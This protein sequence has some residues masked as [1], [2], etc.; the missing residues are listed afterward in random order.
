VRMPFTRPMIA[1]LALVTL[2]LLIGVLRYGAGKALGDFRQHL[3]MFLFF[4]ALRSLTVEGRLQVIRERL[5]HV[6]LIVALYVIATF[7]F[8]R[9]ALNAYA[10]AN[11]LKVLEER[12]VFDNTLFLLFMYAG[13]L[14][15]TL[16]ATRWRSLFVALLLA[17]NV[18]MLIVMQFR[19]Y[20]GAFLVIPILVGWSRRRELLR[21]RTLVGATLAVALILGVAVAATVAGV[22]RQAWGGVATSLSERAESLVRL[23][24]TFR[25]ES[26]RTETEV[27]TLGG[28][29]QTAKVAIDD[30]FLPNPILGIGLGGEL[31]MVSPRGGIVM[32]KYNIDNGFLSILAKF[33]LVGFV[34][35]GVVLL[36]TARSLRRVTRSSFATDDERM[37][38]HS[39][40]VGILAMLIASGF[41][42]A[43][44]RPQTSV[45]AFLILLAETAVLTR[46][47][48]ER[49]AWTP[50][51]EPGQVEG[52]E[53]LLAGDGGAVAATSG[54][55]PGA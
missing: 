21:R 31:P 3:P 20:W 49:K 52:D 6:M 19:T 55:I 29:Y 26:G 37:L 47:V 32:M 35:Y 27:E 51:S 9:P 5:F 44:V 38:A 17:T 48:N 36:R 40:L 10:A 12:V 7:L 34:L 46:N 8:F 14:L 1:C 13:Y 22:G 50:T 24:E 11:G 45:V 4:W 18:A 25:L 15:H 39:M 42:A 23:G 30:Y 53:S 16:V 41:S 2:E 54:E 33:G 28:R 43:F